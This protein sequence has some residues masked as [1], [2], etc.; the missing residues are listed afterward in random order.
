MAIST[1][2]LVS[3]NFARELSSIHYKPQIWINIYIPVL[4]FDMGILHA[5]VWND[6]PFWMQMRIMCVTAG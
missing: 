3:H 4:P 1:K 5:Q 2:E 6:G